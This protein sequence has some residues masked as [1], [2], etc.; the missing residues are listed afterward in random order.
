MLTNG[1]MANVWEAGYRPLGDVHAIT[2]AAT[3]YLRFPGHCFSARSA[4]SAE[5]NVGFRGAKV[6]RSSHTS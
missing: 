4:V 3:Q 5:K 1:S 2:G 6:T